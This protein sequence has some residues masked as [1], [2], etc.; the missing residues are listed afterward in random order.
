MIDIYTLLTAMLVTLFAVISPGPDF[1][2][3]LKNSLSYGRQ[4]GILTAVGIAVGVSCHMMY[5]LLGIG[6]ILTM[7]ETG[8]K[9]L[10][11]GGAAYL[12]WLGISGLRAA[13]VTQIKRTNDNHPQFSAIISAATAF[14]HGFICNLFNPKTSL[15]FIAIFSQ[16]LG[17]LNNLYLNTGFAIFVILSHFIWFALLAHILTNTSFLKLLQNYR[18]GI[19]TFLSLCLIILG[20]QLM[21]SAT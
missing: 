2:I 9:I 1:A 11:Y 21:L 8:Q 16:F 20:G 7:S 18:R 19:D 5:I 15:F 4:T 10:Q 3:T 13:S 14:R 12:I 17:N 6:A